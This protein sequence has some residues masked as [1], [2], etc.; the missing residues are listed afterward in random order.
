MLPVDSAPLVML[1][2][3][4]GRGSWGF[5]S[6]RLSSSVRQPQG[7]Q[8]LSWKTVGDKLLQE[9]GSHGGQAFQGHHPVAK[10][11]GCPLCAEFILLCPE[12]LA[13]VRLEL[14]E[15]PGQS[16]SVLAVKRP[17]RRTLQALSLP[18][19]VAS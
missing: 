14:S 7:F 11:K 15:L 13:C 4:D 2:G 5:L 8:S 12:L 6:S 16:L 1:R 17:K 19:V 9:T 3:G 10:S 18:K